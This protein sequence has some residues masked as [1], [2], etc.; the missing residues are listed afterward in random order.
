LAGA[1]ALAGTS[2]LPAGAAGF[3]GAADSAAAGFSAVGFFSPSEPP[4]GPVLAGW[5][6]AAAVERES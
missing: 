3:A 6:W 2:D 4:D 1:A 5:G